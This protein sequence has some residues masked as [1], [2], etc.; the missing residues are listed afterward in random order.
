[1]S[2][3]P[4]ALLADYYDKILAQRDSASALQLWTETTLLSFPGRNRFS[5]RHIGVGWVTDLYYPAIRKIADIRK[6]ALLSPLVADDEFGLSHYRER[7][8]IRDTGE[9]LIMKRRALY[10]F[11]SG[12]IATV[13][14]FDEESEAIDR[15]LNR[16]WSSESV[17]QDL[18]AR[19]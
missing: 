12:R 16:F 2:I 14:V 11:V 3:T 10:G 15:F 1:M 18:G 8:V 9:E 5:G 19:S 13:R 7:I 6:E 4:L 17:G